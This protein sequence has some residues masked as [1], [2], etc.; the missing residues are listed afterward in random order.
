MKAGHP[1]PQ[2]QA[3]SRVMLSIFVAVIL[4]LSIVATVLIVRGLGDEERQQQYRELRE[5]VR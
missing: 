5:Q 2:P 4:V 1:P 3:R